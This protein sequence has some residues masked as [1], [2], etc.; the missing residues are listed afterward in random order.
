[1]KRS[2]VPLLACPVCRADLELQATE[3]DGDECMSGDLVCSSCHNS[4]DI[5]RGIPRF[6]TTELG[7]D[8][9]ATAEN[10][11]WQ[12][13]HFTQEDPAYAAQFLGWIQ[14]V[15]PENFKGQIVL[16]AGCGKGRHTTLAAQW[17][18]Q[19]VVGIDLSDSVETA[20]AQTRHIGQA[21]IVQGDLHSLPLKPVFDY[22]FSVGVLH[23]TPDP[24]TAFLSVASAVKTGGRFSAWVYGAENNGWITRFVNPLRK[25]FTSRLSPRLL[26]HGSKVPAALLFAIT[27]LVYGPMNTLAPGLARRLFYTDYLVSLASFGWREHHT[28]VFDHLVAPT[29][30]YIDRPQFESWWRDLG[31]SDLTMIWNNRNSW[32]GSGRL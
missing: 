18:A 28:I 16:D 8:Q 32:S 7:A 24:R 1:M 20:F 12:W 30:F 17:G 5:V 13:S 21:H 11:G 6:V 23:H 14:P 31:A 3:W 25:H 27:K 15:L 29:A 4:W 10:F 26:L 22:V 19:V 9:A 2:L